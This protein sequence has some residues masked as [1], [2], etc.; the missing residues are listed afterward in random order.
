MTSS[1]FIT[2]LIEQKIFEDI[3]Y[4]AKKHGLNWDIVLVATGI[5][6]KT[7]VFWATLTSVQRKYSR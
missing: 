7:Q 6:Y 5:L 1:L 2:S 4:V 3:T